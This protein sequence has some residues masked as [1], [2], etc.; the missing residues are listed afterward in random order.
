MVRS[1]L[2]VRV[3]CVFLFGALAVGGG[4]GGGSHADDSERSTSGGTGTG[5]GGAAGSATTAAGGMSQ[6]GSGASSSKGGAGG[7]GTGGSGTAGSNS[8]GTGA[9]AS[10]GSSN[11][12]M[13]NAG[14]GGSAGAGNAGSGQAGSTLGDPGGE[15]GN[16]G[17]GGS[18]G[19]GVRFVGFINDGPDDDL[20]ASPDVATLFPECEVQTSGT[21]PPYPRFTECHARGVV[22]MMNEKLAEL[23]SDAPPFHFESFDIVVDPLLYNWDS[24]SGGGSNYQ[25]Q[26][27][28]GP[29]YRVPNTMT[30]TMPSLAHGDASGL[31]LEDQ[32]LSPDFG[33]LSIAL[34]MQGTYVFLHEFGHDL[35]FPHA[36]N[37]AGV[38]TSQYDGCGGVTLDP[39]ACLCEYANY[40][41]IGTSFPDTSGCAAC[42][43]SEGTTWDTPFFGPKYAA[44]A[45]CWLTRRLEPSPVAFVD[46][47]CFGL[48]GSDFAA[49][50]QLEAG[51]V[52]CQCPSGQLFS[53]ADCSD[54]TQDA[55]NAATIASCDHITCAP[56][57]E[58]PG[59]VCDG[60]AGTTNIQCTCEDHSTLFYLG[61]D[62]STL[63]LDAIEQICP[64]PP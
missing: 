45:E 44:I 52:T 7:G 49:C 28:Q 32:R 40:M 8:G 1:K 50:K 46:G 31:S 20:P 10:G 37:A 21:F 42:E 38:G 47:D 9:D 59:V 33:M 29:T 23:I 19:I 22:R 64:T 55:R 4:C 13:P 43:Y 16:P 6:A 39:P 57:P 48:T 2:G 3:G 56:P 15:G 12:G 54:A 26:H 36:G 41:S 25:M 60:L 24:T 63:S 51:A 58:R 17:D 61:S 62:C 30:F 5:T 14:R 11:G 34:P 35:G 18:G 53:F 27:L